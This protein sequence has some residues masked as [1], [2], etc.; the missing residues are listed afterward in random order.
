MRA[1]LLI[2]AAGAVGTGARYLV[3]TAAQKALGGPFAWGTLAVNALGCLMA[4]VLMELILQ[5][6]LVPQDLRLPLSVG[7]LGA[8]TTFSTFGHETFRYLD[9]GDWKLALTYV[10]AQLVLG[11]VAVAAGVALG[12]SVLG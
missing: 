4:G 7:F 8:F 3:S 9:A 10:G 2:C 12:R 1:F 5:S 11:L 6:D